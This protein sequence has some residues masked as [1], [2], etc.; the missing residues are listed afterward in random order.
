[1]RVDDL[2]Q[3]IRS[4]P[5]FPAPGVLFRDITP[6]L[7]DPVS[8]SRALELLAEPWQ[9][10]GIDL[11]AGVE[12]RGF[13]VGV[14][15]AERLGVGFVPV[16]K[17]GKLPWATE[18]MEYQLEYGTAAVE[19]HRDAIEPGQRIL[20][21]DDLLATGGTASAVKELVERA[22]GEVAGFG[23]LIELL[24]LGGRGKLDGYR[25]VSLL[26]FE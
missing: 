11:V 12:A 9:G 8:L 1:M 21:M 10:A 16:R 24:S 5:D 7:R 3:K 19:I 20:I 18:H 13:I 14:P 15:V 22:G 4:I 23:F 25:V 17:P 2:A 6:L 26:Q